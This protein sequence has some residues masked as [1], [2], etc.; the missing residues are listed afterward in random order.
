VRM[1]HPPTQHRKSPDRRPQRLPLPLPRPLRTS[2]LYSAPNAGVVFRSATP[3]SAPNV[4]PQCRVPSS[5][6]AVPPSTHVPFSLVCCD[7]LG[8]QRVFCLCSHLQPKPFFLPAVISPRDLRSL[9]YRHR[10]PTPFWPCYMA[11]TTWLSSLSGKY[12]HFFPRHFRRHSF[13][14]V[15]SFKESARNPGDGCCVDPPTPGP[16]AHSPA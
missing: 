13:P 16:L 14:L 11:P 1:P 2:R 10:P 3:P 4:V 12:P 5:N 8:R 7:Q 6:G 9:I 15:L